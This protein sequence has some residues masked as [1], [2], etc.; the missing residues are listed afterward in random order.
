MAYRVDIADRAQRDFASLYAAIDAEH[1]GTA[2]KWYVGLKE[3]ILGL[4][5][6]PH[7]CPVIRKKRQIRQLLY[8]SKSRVYLVLY[9]ILEKQKV[10]QVLHIRHGARQRLGHSDLESGES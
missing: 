2:R 5:H 10:V 7:R 4:E 6:L 9:R 3:A 1:S 8:S